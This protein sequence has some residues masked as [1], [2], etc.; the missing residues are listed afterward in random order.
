MKTS[1]DRE[2]PEGGHRPWRVEREGALHSEGEEEEGEDGGEWGRVI[3]VLGQKPLDKSPP[4]KS[5]RYKSQKKKPGVGFFLGLVNPSRSRLASTAYFAK[6][7]FIVL[8][9]LF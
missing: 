3:W 5:P 6:P 2:Q 9:E 8:V 7:G 4:T 1:G